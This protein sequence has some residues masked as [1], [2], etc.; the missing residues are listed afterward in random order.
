MNIII[1]DHGPTMLTVC[2]RYASRSLPAEDLL[3]E[4]FIKVFK[5]LDKFDSGKGAFAPWIRKITANV[6]LSE[7]RKLKITFED[8]PMIDR[9]M[10]DLHFDPFSI[11]DIIQEIEKLP[12][13]YKV[14]FNMKEIEG[15][16][17]KEIAEQFNIK[18]ST[19]RTHLFRAKQILQ[20]RL[21][22]YRPQL[23][24]KLCHER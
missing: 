10:E 6:C 22:T 20:K 4:A 12:I 24:S 15:Y 5:N 17:H 16:S 23:T 8:L 2:R 18:E 11:E 9:L 3:Q 7:I 14:V 19:S 13:A 21:G 1:Y